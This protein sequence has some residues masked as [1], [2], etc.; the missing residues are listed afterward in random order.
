MTENKTYTYLN[1][2][3]ALMG[4]GCVKEIGKHAKDLGA[5]KALIVSGKSKHGERLALDI[6]KIL[7]DA[8]LEGTIFPGADPNPTDTSVMEGADIYRKEDCNI[9]IAVGG[10][11]PMDCAKA[12]GIVVYNGG[13]INDY[14]GV[15]KVTKG[16]PPLITVNTTAGTA[17]EMTSFTI[18]TDTKRHIKMAIVDPRITPYI[19]VNDP[20][21]M[22]SMPP[23]LTAATG[24]DALTHAVE[25]YV[26]TM[27]TPTTDAA[28]I[29]S[30]ELISKYLR[31]AVAHGED[32]RTRDMMAHAEYLAGIA[33]NNASLGYVHSMA[34]QLGGLYNL[35]HGV[36]NAILL[37]YVEAYNKKVVPER[38]ADIARAMG[39]KVEGLSHEEAADRAIEAI[40][41]LALDIG[42]P[43]GLKELGAKE[44]D[45][46]LLA[47]H[48]MQDV[49]RRTNPREL[50]KEDIIE[51]YRKAL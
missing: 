19:A 40:R 1:P 34:H 17:S 6:Y 9:I 12:I 5:T 48:A 16:I 29:K 20:E 28:A 21:L 2:K 18:I 39:E 36:C 35:P 38:F 42:I 24:M 4:A 37:P 15:G 23:A 22:V 45:L 10:G 50:S 47:E 51:I 8:G 30:I 44:E 31:E 7:K 33:F 13:L 41:K 43:S 25:A 46:E 3:V 11:S 32:V 26:S 27:A 14:E 49:C